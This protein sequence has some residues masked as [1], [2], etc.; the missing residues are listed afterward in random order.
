MAKISKFPVNKIAFRTGVRI[1]FADAEDDIEFLD[2][3]YIDIGHVEQALATE[4][5]G[6][7]LV[8][9][10]GCGKTAA[11]LKIIST[12]DHVIRIDPEDLAL[13][14][15]SNSNILSFFHGI[16]V[17]LD[18]FFQLLWRHV[19][20]VELL[21]Y[22][23]NIRDVNDFQKAI[24]SIKG[25]VVKNE[26]KK[27]S[28]EYL[29]EWGTHFWEQTQERIK[30]I[31]TG[32]ENDLQA[33]VDLTNLGVPLNAQGSAKI[34]GEKKFELVTDATKVVNEVQIKKLSV[35]MNVIA[36][37]IF[38][39][40]QNKYYIVIDKLDENWV[41]DALRYRLIRSLIEAIKAFRKIRTVKLVIALRQDLIE[42]VYKYTKSGGFQEEKYEDFHIP[43]TWNRDNLYLLV[44]RRIG[45][46]FRRQYTKENVQF[47]DI[48]PSRYRQQGKT[49]DYLIQRTQMRPRDIIAFI[50]TIFIQVVGKNTITAE[51]IDKA[52]IIYSKK[53]LR[54][55]C[56]EWK[57]EYPNLELCLEV[58]RRMPTRIDYWDLS[59]EIFERTI[60]SLCDRPEAPDNMPQIA[61]NFMYDR[62]S[63][64][65]VRSNLVTIFY[66]IGAVG[67]KPNKSEPVHFSFHS[68]YEL[69]PEDLE[70]GVR[71]SVAPM[72]W[73]ALGNMR[74]RRKGDIIGP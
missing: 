2:Q 11:I 59:E 31:V 45:E 60:L 70:K 48:F 24:E 56:T 1:G 69:H 61:N 68:S 64:E 9:R 5:P 22:H 47:N 46:L 65:K 43:I 52:E 17:D 39:N 44:N 67:V 12:Q 16:G 27:L 41:D 32:F 40:K 6:S 30:E 34:H 28:L 20:C 33:G 66:K 49:F 19:L 38:T 10:T 74:V 54:A 25:I 58:L 36:D 15:I 42:R 8:G 29:E 23:Y 26:G 63:F 18:L 14:F 21:N 73:S 50:N 71:L 35:L 53:R 4:D 37:D 62:C 55:L 51:D 7:I 13:N 72:L 3:C 57:D